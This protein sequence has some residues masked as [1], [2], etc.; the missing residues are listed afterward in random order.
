MSDDD[1]RIIINC[2]GV[3][4]ETYR[5]TLRSIPDT[6]LAWVAENTQIIANNY[7]AEKNEYELFF[8]RHPGV[9]AAII[10]REL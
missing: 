6:R 7:D 1:E 5:S 3:R 9:F 4:H 8:D 2:G 10:N